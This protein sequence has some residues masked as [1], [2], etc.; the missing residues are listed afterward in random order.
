MS[1]ATNQITLTEKETSLF[2]S[3]VNGMDEVFTGWLHEL[4]HNLENASVAGVV[5]SLVKKGLITTQHDEGCD[6]IEVTEKGKMFFA[7]TPQK[8]AAKLDHGTLVTAC[9][10]MHVEAYGTKLDLVELKT[11]ELAALR[12]FF[13]SMVKNAAVVPS[14]SAK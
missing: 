11:W 10:V 4:N 7:I 12:D 8:V 2:Y 14:I 6:W 3:A 13:T 9:N 5:S 1:N